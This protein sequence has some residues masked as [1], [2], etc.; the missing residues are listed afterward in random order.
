M[1]SMSVSSQGAHWDTQGLIP[2]WISPPFLFYSLNVLIASVQDPL[3]K[4]A[5]FFRFDTV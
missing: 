4:K 5:P 1:G 3:E 2:F